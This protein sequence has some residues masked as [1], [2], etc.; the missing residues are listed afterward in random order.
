MAW[1]AAAVDKPASLVPRQDNAETVPALYGYATMAASG[2]VHVVLILDK[3]RLNPQKKVA[4]GRCDP[5]KTMQLITEFTV[6]LNR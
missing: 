3:Q 6:F 2:R 1:I 4:S 5:L